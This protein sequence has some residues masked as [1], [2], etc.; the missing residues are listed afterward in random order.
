[1]MFDMT[2][3]NQRQNNQSK[4]KGVSTNQSSTYVTESGQAKDAWFREEEVMRKKLEKGAINQLK[5][6]IAQQ[7]RAAGS[8]KPQPDT[9]TNEGNDS[10]MDPNEGKTEQ[11]MGSAGGAV[12]ATQV[13]LN[14]IQVEEAK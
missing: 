2:A 9:Q 6:R 13:Q 8:S 1:M 3:P 11:E 4:V 14:P 5:S 12:N 10:D 7:N